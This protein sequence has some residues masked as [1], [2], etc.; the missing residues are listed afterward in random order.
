M[1]WR[2]SIIVA[3]VSRVARV[4]S[5]GLKAFLG[6]EMARR[7]GEIGFGQKNGSDLIQAI[8]AIAAQCDRYNLGLV[9]AR[10]TIGI[11]STRATTSG[12]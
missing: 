4:G 2:L 10:E 6:R 11:V 1:K 8:L 12:R 3:S 5:L 7:K 9:L